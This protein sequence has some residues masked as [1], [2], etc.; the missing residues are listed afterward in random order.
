MDLQPKFEV[1]I[2]LFSAEEL[3][4]RNR[5]IDLSSDDRRIF[6]H[7]TIRG[8]LPTPASVFHRKEIQTLPL[9]VQMFVLQVSL[10]GH[11]RGQ[12]YNKTES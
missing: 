8:S 9:W 7:G 3:I 4:M 1:F 11:R 12:A 10:R 6:L 5:L 2:L